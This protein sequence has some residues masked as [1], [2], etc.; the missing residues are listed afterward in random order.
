MMP[1][2]FS[3]SVLSPNLGS[4]EEK[5]WE[6]TTHHSSLQGITVGLHNTIMDASKARK[7]TLKAQ[8]KADNRRPFW[9]R[10]S[11]FR[12]SRH[13]TSQVSDSKHLQ[14]WGSLGH[15][16]KLLIMWCQLWRRPFNP[17][18]RDQL[19]KHLEI[20]PI[21]LQMVHGEESKFCQ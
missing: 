2:I 9:T 1:K 21:W 5:W 18:L 16:G 13:L 10:L 15:A 3:V 8:K 19:V 6:I 11:G 20:W 7:C 17:K 4:K 14:P 12:K